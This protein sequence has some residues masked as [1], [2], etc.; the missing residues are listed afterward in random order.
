MVREQVPGR[1]RHGCKFVNG[2]E[3]TNELPSI[4]L[5]SNKNS[6]FVPMLKS[7]THAFARA[8]AHD[9]AFLYDLENASDEWC[10]GTTASAYTESVDT[11]T[12]R[13]PGQHDLYRDLRLR[14]MIT[15]ADG[16]TVGTVT[17]SINASHETRRAGVRM[18]F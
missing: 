13:Q 3:N 18:P 9:S 15:T 7:D 17:T 12:I 10:S 2:T 5:H 8:G 14:L 1:E 4:P 6:I 16:T 11:G